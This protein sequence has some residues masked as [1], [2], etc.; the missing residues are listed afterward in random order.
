MNVKTKFPP[1]VCEKM[2][3]YVYLLKDPDTKEVFYI[4]KGKGNR[5]F[6]HVTQAF[7]SVNNPEDE[8]EKLNKIR[9]IQRRGKEVEHVILR[10]NLGEKEAL[11][12]EAS[13]LDYIGIEKLTNEVR[14]YRTVLQGQR[15]VVDIL[16]EYDARKI[17]IS[18]PVILIRVNWLFRYGMSQDELYEITR[19][20]WKL[21]VRREKASFAFSVYNGIVRQVY[22]I[23]KDKWS[24]ILT[25]S[26][27]G[28]TGERWR[29]EGKVADDLKRYVG[30]SV[31]HYLKQGSQNP[32]KYINC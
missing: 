29:F 1:S 4:G 11:H 15:N 6:E 3:Y 19:G 13:L 12:V 32:I 16:S 20:N 30:R 8:S 18:E 23:E 2:G 26:K 24:M 14:G 25:H 28:I 9:G 17:D 21:G 5:V 27:S 7:E 22:A 10:H 31:E